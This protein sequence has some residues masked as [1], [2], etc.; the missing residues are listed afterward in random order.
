MPPAGYPSA[1][2]QEIATLENWI[3]AGYPATGCTPDAGTLPDSGATSPDAGNPQG[4]DAGDPL[5][6]APTCTS[7]GHWLLG[8][9]GVDLMH[10]G[11]DCDGCHAMHGKTIFQIAGTLYPTG[12]EPDDCDG[13]RSAGTIVI[14][15]ADGMQIMLTPNYNGNFHYSGP[16]ATPF[17]AKVVLNG[18]ERPMLTPQTSGDC[19]S[20]HTQDGT[21]M[22]PGRVTI[23]Y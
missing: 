17:T 1:T 2:S 22:A 7:N 6:A 14:T 20:C 5:N 3:S 19:N 18:K 4:P 23:P 13:Y 8:D 21:N 16:L 11:G 10:P 9:L 12:H 15:G